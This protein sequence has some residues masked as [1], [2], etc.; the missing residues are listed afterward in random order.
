MS[1]DLKTLAIL[2]RFKSFLTLFSLHQKVETEQQQHMEPGENILGT[3]C[4][5]KEANCILRDRGSLQAELLLRLIG[6]Q[7]PVMK[8]WGGV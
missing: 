6:K 8:L 3:A 7:T 5:I 4:V 1:L 2:A